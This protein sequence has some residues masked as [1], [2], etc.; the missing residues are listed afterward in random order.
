M[1]GVRVNVSEEVDRNLNFLPNRTLPSEHHLT[2][3]HYAKV[4]FSS[5]GLVSHDTFV[6]KDLFLVLR[7]CMDIIRPFHA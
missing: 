3:V 5:F 6:E 2:F 1:L 4:I 7:T